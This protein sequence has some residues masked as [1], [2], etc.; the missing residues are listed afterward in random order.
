MRNRGWFRVCHCASKCD[1]CFQNRQA[2]VV[3]VLVGGKCGG[4]GRLA[5]GW[6]RTSKLRDLADLVVDVQASWLRG[7]RDAA[8]AQQVDSGRAV[9]RQDWRLETCP[10]TK[11]PHPPTSRLSSA[12]GSVYAAPFYP[13]SRTEGPT[14]SHLTSAAFKLKTFKVATLAMRVA[15]EAHTC[16]V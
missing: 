14:S 12:G 3:N 2:D 15:G 13:T 4:V 16:S 9:H 1:V 7:L 10:G 6:F 11:P 5:E 8:A